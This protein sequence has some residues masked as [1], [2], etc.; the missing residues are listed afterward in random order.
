MPFGVRAEQHRLEAHDRRVAR[1]QVRDRLDAA[2]PLDRG[3]DDQRVH[4]DPRGR[5]VVDVDVAGEAGVAHPR[6]DLEQALVV[7]AERRVDLDRRD[8]PALAQVGREPRLVLGALGRRG[9]LALDDLERRRRRP[10]L[11]DRAPDRGD[12]GRRRAAAAADHLG[13]EL[14]RVRGELGE[15]LGRGVRVDDAAAGQAGEADVRQRR[16]RQ[17]R[18]PSPAAPTA[19]SAARR[20]GSSR[21][22]PRPSSRSRAAASAAVTPPI[23]SAS[24]PKVII[25]TIGRL[26]TD[27]T[28]S[29]AVTSSSRSKNVSTMNRSTPRP[30]SSAACSAKS[31]RVIL[32][33]G[34]LVLAEGPD[35]ARR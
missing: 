4:A 21:S 29:I 2:L 6:G 14:A 15:V 22:R 34:L 35:R 27:R 12:L 1:G 3:R 18:R 30:A 28:A 32:G 17:A 23:V 26:E 19:Q 11:V 5:V 10:L 8:E 20:R 24:S 13:A 7:G 16:E 9:E 25:A 33:P 31:G